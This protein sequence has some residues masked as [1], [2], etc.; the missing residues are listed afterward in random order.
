[1]TKPIRSGGEAMPESKK[2]AVRNLD[3]RDLESELLTAVNMA[4]IA[5]DQIESAQNKHNRTI[6][7]FHLSEDEMNLVSFAVYH[8]SDLINALKKKWDDVHDANIAPEGGAV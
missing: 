3:Y 8:T 7:G 4:E 1:M 6:S 5:C 2:T